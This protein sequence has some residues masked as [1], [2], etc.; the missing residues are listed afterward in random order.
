[1][2]LEPPGRRCGP[3][4]SPSPRF[5]ALSFRLNTNISFLPSVSVHLSV[6]PSV[7][8][9]HPA[10]AGPP[11]LPAP[12]RGPQ[13]GCSPHLRAGLA[14]PTWGAAHGPHLH[15]RYLSLL[16]PTGNGRREGPPL[17]PPPPASLTLHVPQGGQRVASPEQVARVCSLCVPV[18]VCA[19]VPVCTGRGA[20]VPRG[21]FSTSP[22]PRGSEGLQ[23]GALDPSRGRKLKAHLDV[24][25]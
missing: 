2:S 10:R 7:C 5:R 1:M 21:H 25:A 19:V 15:L 14:A 4:L 3:G 24:Q 6:C 22:P 18:S 16:F 12:L 17:R 20:G 23:E 13:Q 8:P 11:P 9:A